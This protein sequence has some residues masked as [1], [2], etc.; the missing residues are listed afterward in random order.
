MANKGG[1]L[2]NIGQAL[3]GYGSALSGNPMYLQNSLLLRQAQQ[4]QA[5]REEAKQKQAM[6]TA[7]LQELAKRGAQGTP[8]FVGPRTLEGQLFGRQAMDAN[9]L[10][11][12]ANPEAAAQL[13]MQKLGMGA[14]RAPIVAKPGEVVLDPNNNYAQIASVPATPEAPDLSKQF[15]QTFGTDVPTGYAPVIVNGQMTGAVRPLT[16]MKDVN[17]DKP[18]ANDYM[19]DPRNPGARVMVPGGSAAVSRA[20]A[21]AEPVW[22]ERKLYN[23]SATQYATMADLVNDDTGASD[24]SLVY[25]FFKANDP[26]SSVRESEFATIGEKMGLPAKIIGEIKSLQSGKGFLTP[27]TRT[28]LLNSAGRAIKQRKATLQRS[29]KDVSSGLAT[30]GVDRSA[31]LPFNVSDVN[32]ADVR[33]Q[34]PDAK[35]DTAGRVYVMR[36]GKRAYVELDE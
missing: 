18:P 17:A 9:D 11:A 33:K 21:L 35:Q 15:K 19:V 34:F 23:E 22:A 10:L 26:I 7:D 36:N 1:T 24:I 28:A 20:Q 29:Y 32:L 3:S 25:S 5:D 27:A 16:G 12:R 30:L 31:F 8:N 6:Q 13:A 14:P 4:Q 2:A